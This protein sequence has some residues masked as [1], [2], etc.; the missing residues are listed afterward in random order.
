MWNGNWDTHAAVKWLSL[1][2]ISSEYETER[3]NFYSPHLVR[4]NAHPLVV[5][6]GEDVVRAL[7]RRHLYRYLASTEAIEIEMVNPA[8]M[9]VMDSD[10]APEAIH[11]AYKVYTDEGFHALMCVQLRESVADGEIPYLQRYKNA[12]LHSVMSLREL[13]DKND[14]NLVLLAITC[15]NETMIAASLSQAT[16]H[17][18][19]PAL[20]QIVMAHARDEAAHN[21][22]FTKLMSQ[23]WPRLST[24]EK[25]LLAELMPAIF[26]RLSLS[27]E[28]GVRRDLIAEGF[29]DGEASI[30]CGELFGNPVDI[31]GLRSVANSSIRMLT[32]AGFWL[33]PGAVESFRQQGLAQ[34]VPDAYL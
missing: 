17:T 12:A 21:V 5:R 30:V 7:Q 8:L 19:Y 32:K 27:D 18:V 33:H 13:P 1:E 34:L 6:R 10:I 23:F 15:V 26:N 24:R 11:D 22:Y 4:V 29:D 28:A 3:M 20:R 16:D 2:E 25:N 14:S 31:D 9:F